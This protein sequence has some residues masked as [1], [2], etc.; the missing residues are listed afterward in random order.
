MNNIWEEHKNYW[1][2]DPEIK[3]IVRCKQC[4]HH[5]NIFDSSVYCS[6]KIGRFTSIINIMPSHYNSG[7]LNGESVIRCVKKRRR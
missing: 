1:R 3:S 7:F 5:E 2:F 6:N 4:K